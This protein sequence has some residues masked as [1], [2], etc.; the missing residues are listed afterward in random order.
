[1]SYRIVIAE[2]EFILANNLKSLVE[3]LNHTVVGIAETGAQA[4]SL[5]EQHHPDLILMDIKLPEVDGITAARSI[6]QQYHIPTVIISAFS[7]RSYIEEAAEAG[8]MTYLVK[9]VSLGDLQAVIDLTMARYRELMALRQEVGDLK[10]ALS[11]RKIVERAKGIM[12][13]SLHLSEGEAF[14]RLQQLS[15]RE[16]RPMIDIAQ[17]VITANTLWK[18]TGDHLTK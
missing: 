1:M 8:V 4:I 2:D 13:D 11:Q 6:A 16:N 17:A 15:Q 9:P 14:R 7:D 10:N 12:M 3:S 5:A 18:D